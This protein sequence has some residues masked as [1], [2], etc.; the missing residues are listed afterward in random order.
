MADKRKLKW[1]VNVSSFILLSV[2]T[3]TGLINWLFLPRGRV[4]G[5]GLVSG[6]RH[7]LIGVHELSAILFIVAIA[8]HI[9]LHW[10]YVKSNLKGMTAGQ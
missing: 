5:G 9:G 8:I 3:L 1:M 7:F 4:A 10:S 6:A 2:L